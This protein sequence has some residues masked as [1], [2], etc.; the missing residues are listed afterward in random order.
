MVMQVMEGNAAKSI[1]ED[2]RAYGGFIRM[3][4]G[5]LQEDITESLVNIAWIDELGFDSNRLNIN[6][7]K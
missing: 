2:G 6:S 4:K 5:K 3:A 1:E 7:K